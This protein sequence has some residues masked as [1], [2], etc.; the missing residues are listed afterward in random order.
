MKSRNFANK[1]L[2]IAFWVVICVSYLT[3]NCLTTLSLTLTPASTNQEK[4]Y[5]LNQYNYNQPTRESIY[6]ALDVLDYNQY[7]SQ[8]STDTVIVAVVD[9]GLDYTHTVFENRIVKKYAVDFSQGIP[10][11]DANLWYEDDRGHGTHVA[12]IIADMTLSNVKILPI[13]IFYGLNNSG[14]EYAFENAIRYLCALKTGKKVGLLNNSGQITSYYTPDQK[15][16]NLVA[17]N[18]SLGTDG[19]WT[20][21]TDDMKKYNNLKPGFQNMIDHLVSCDILPI[22]A[23]GNRTSEQKNLINKNK[24]YY[25]LPGSCEGTV[26]VSA[27]DNTS[28]QYAIANFSYFN[29]Y[30]TVS[31]P[32]VEIWSACSQN[33]V[34]R[35]NKISNEDK[36]ERTD[37]VGKYIHYKYESTSWDI[38]RDDEGNYYLRD[39]GT[40]MATPF[41]TACYAML[42]SD[43]SK[44]QASDYGL[45]STSQDKSDLVQQALVANAA[46]NGYNTTGKNDKFGYGTVSLVGMNNVK[47]SQLEDIEYETPKADV[48]W[49]SDSYSGGSSEADWRTVCI[50]L[51]VSIVIIRIINSIRSKRNRREE[52]DNNY[53]NTI[54]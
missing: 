8:I 33:I 50:I 12:G 49:W 47:S 9:T 34:N 54:E 6:D 1:L 42:Y 24:T 16:E 22:V 27:Y 29:K 39:N 15:L 14:A 2:L 26:T 30:V 53:D 46:T 25:C 48:S 40:S 20:E 11:Q 13:K 37:S 19:Y 32:G 5:L 52:Y 41:V 17:V 31:A 4:V 28:S 21:S 10:T 45:N 51:L 23:A 36:T 38:R 7:L 3:T 18:L 43:T 35:L 44:Q